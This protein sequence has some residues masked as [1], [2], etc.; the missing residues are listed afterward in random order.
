M[1]LPALTEAELAEIRRLLPSPMCGVPPESC[2]VALVWLYSMNT[3]PLVVTRQDDF[4]WCNEIHSFIPLDGLRSAVI[5][6][7]RELEAAVADLSH[8]FSLNA[9]DCEVMLAT[10][11]ERVQKLLKGD[12]HE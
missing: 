8:R 7:R 11:V 9:D 1:T 2:R 10:I 6:Y 5:D 3:K 12:S 4:D